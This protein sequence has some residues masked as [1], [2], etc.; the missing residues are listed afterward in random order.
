M[1]IIEKIIK[2][3]M[4]QNLSLPN[5]FTLLGPMGFLDSSVV[6]NLP[7]LQETGVR[8]PA[9]S[10]P[11]LGRSPGEGTR[12]SLQCSCPGNPLVRGA[13]RATVHGIVKESDTA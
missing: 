7:A 12:D 3:I 5:Y 1:L 13:W 9:G 2:V 8:S 11:G 10:I 6:K 4:S